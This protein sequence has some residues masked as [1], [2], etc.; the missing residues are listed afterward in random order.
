M[1]SRVPTPVAAVL[2]LL[3]S[4]VGAARRLPVQAVTLPVLALSAALTKVESAR[5]GYDDLARRGEELLTRRRGGTDAPPATPAKDLPLPYPG[6]R[7]AGTAPAPAADPAPTASTSPATPAAPATPPPP[8]K[9]VEVPSAKIDTAAAA[10]V[11]E[12][13]ADVVAAIN[14]DAV[15]RHAD[16]PLPDYDHLTLGSLRG[17]LRSL[18]L[19]QLVQVRDY[20]KGKADRLPVVTMLDNRIARLATAGDEPTGGPTADATPEQPPRPDGASKVGPASGARQASAP[21]S[22]VRLT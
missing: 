17:R 12:V 6:E 20:E 10:D 13:V 19:E 7:A 8:P 1:P 21:R 22:K 3:P 9:V 4:A 16:L 5:R 2:G 18:T 11:V 14:A 15:T